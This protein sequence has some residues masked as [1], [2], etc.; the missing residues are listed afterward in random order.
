MSRSDKTKPLWVRHKEHHPQPV[1]DH[2]RGPCDLPPRP[3][4]WETG[5]RCQWED[6]GAQLGSHTCCA[7]CGR[8]GCTKDQQREA[9]NRNR[10]G[11]YA[12]RRQARQ[13]RRLAAE[14]GDEQTCP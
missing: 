11:R 14:R 3:T 13:A 1:H 5:T 9:R 8:P 2:R 4:R 7:G 10:K 6:P 12:G